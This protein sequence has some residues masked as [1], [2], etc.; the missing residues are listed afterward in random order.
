MQV[1]TLTQGHQFLNYP[2]QFFCLGKGCFNLF[3]F[4]ERAGHIRPE[5]LAVFMGSVKPAVASCV[6][7]ISYPSTGFFFVWGPMRVSLSPWGWI[8]QS[9]G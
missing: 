8:A 3:M 2:A 9:N 7:H 1:A 5:R 6:T 4:N